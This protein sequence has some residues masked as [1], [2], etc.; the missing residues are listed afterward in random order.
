M[1]RKRKCEKAIKVINY[2][3][4][5]YDGEVKTEQIFI[6]THNKSCLEN[7]MDVTQIL[8]DDF[9]YFSI[10]YA[11]NI[12]SRKSQQDSVAV[13][14]NNIDSPC[15]EKRICAVLSD[16][17]GGL[18][19][20]EIAS[21]LCTDEMIRRFS[22]KTNI[23][24]YPLFFKDSIMEIDMEVKNLKSPSGAALGA[25]ATFISFII[26]NDDLYWATVGD[27]HL[28]I[29]S[30]DEI[31]L[32][33]REHN[34]ML[35]LMDKVKNGEI[36]LKEAQSNKNK[37]ALVSYIG[38]GGLTLF[39]INST[40]FK[41]DSNDIVLACSDGLYRSLSDNEI[42]NTAK[43]CNNDM[44]LLAHILVT[45]ALMKELKHQDNISVIVIKNI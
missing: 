38:M 5:I 30:G 24:N 9:K 21:K 45:K 8:D 26:D 29:I 35:R 27:S 32:V 3:P 2:D 23:E 33:N 15:K 13:S 41:L 16:G 6:E 20:G 1:R 12:G 44:Q 37:N 42:K 39:D 22:A 7:E 17:M 40:P 11:K 43:E 31:E 14:A 4:F 34:Y 28:Y 18:R 10:G 25:G 36:T 19:G